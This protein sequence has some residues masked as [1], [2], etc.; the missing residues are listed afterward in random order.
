[1]L[2]DTFMSTE[3]QVRALRLF[4]NTINI[5]LEQQLEEKG[6]GESGKMRLTFIWQKPLD[7]GKRIIV[8]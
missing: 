3:N 5:I 7:N 1:M 6:E 8:S 4:K 2:A